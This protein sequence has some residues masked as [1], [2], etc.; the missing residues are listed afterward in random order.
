MKHLAQVI[1]AGAMTV[2]MAVFSLAITANSAYAMSSGSEGTIHLLEEGYISNSEVVDTVIAK[3][4]VQLTDISTSEGWEGYIG[5]PLKFQPTWQNPQ[6]VKQTRT[7]GMVSVCG[8][9]NYKVITSHLPGTLGNSYTYQ[10]WGGTGTYTS[11]SAMG[12][13]LST[14]VSLVCPGRYAGQIRTQ[15]YRGGDGWTWSPVRGPYPDNYETGS[16]CHAFTSL[17]KYDA[18]RLS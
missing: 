2:I 4:S 12:Y 18:I 15:Y 10:C 3:V 6:Y 1:G 16:Y 7:P 13:S 8:V 11:S 9:G 17:R 5:G 14:G